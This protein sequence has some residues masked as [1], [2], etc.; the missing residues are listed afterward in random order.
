MSRCAVAGRSVRAVVILWPIVS[1][2]VGTAR[3]IDAA[4]WI[5]KGG[6]CLL[7]A[8]PADDDDVSFL[9]AVPALEWKLISGSCDSPSPSPLRCRLDPSSENRRQ[10]PLSCYVLWRAPMRLKVTSGNWDTFC[11]YPHDW[12][13]HGHCAAAAAATALYRSVRY[14]I[15]CIRSAVRSQFDSPTEPSRGGI[16]I[17][18][19]SV[20]SLH[21]RWQRGQ[22]IC[23]IK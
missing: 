5:K 10:G 23:I 21:N 12:K 3:R 22:S 18:E 11:R 4:D 6:V 1:S 2:M 17:F 9:H 14:T 20:H 15:H 13:W 7:L 8:A 19:S 16:L